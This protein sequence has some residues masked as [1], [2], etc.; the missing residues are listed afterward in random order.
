MLW[1]VSIRSRDTLSRVTELGVRDYRLGDEHAIAELFTICFGRTR[2]MEEWRW[3]FADPPTERVDIRVLCDPSGRIVG[4]IATVGFATS[5]DGRKTV[6]RLTGDLMVHPDFRGRKG[7]ELLVDSGRDL[8]YDL[9]LDT[10]TEGPRKVGE[11]RGILRFHAPLRQW[12]RWQGMPIRAVSELARP[13]RTRVEPLLDPGAE[14]D[15]L[16]EASAEFAPCIRMRTARYLRWRW[17]EQPDVDWQLWAARNRAGVLRGVVAF[18]LDLRRDSA[19]HGRVVDLLARDAE[20]SRVLLMAAA[21]EL[22]HRGC[23]IISFAYQDPRPWSLRACYLAGFLPRGQGPLFSGGAQ[24]EW[25]R[26]LADR[27]ESW[28]LTLGDTDLC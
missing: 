8:P 9:R 5:V 7:V 3:R 20:S 15:A 1:T 13:L 24:Q 4:H 14:V 27:F 12:V 28:Y 16:A 10:P 18:G 23:R 19:R 17:L 21:R 11:R 22:G 6:C 25:T 2:S 26:P